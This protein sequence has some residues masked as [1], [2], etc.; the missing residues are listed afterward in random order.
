MR[1]HAMRG[2]ATR[3]RTLCRHVAALACALASAGAHAG[4]EL[5]AQAERFRW[6][7]GTSPRVTETGPRYGLGWSYES[8]ERGAWQLAYHGRLYGGSRLDYEGALLATNA[9]TRAQTDYRGVLNEVQAHY[10][11]GPDAYAGQLVGG[12]GWDYW[13]RKILPDQRE[14]YSVVYLRLGFSVDPPLARGWFGGGGFKLPVRIA[15]DAHLDTLGFDANPQLNPKGALSVYGEAGYR[16][17]ARWGL[18]AYYDS[19]RFGESRGVRVV[20]SGIPACT[21]GCDIVQPASRVDAVGLRLQYRL[22]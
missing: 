11:L 17:N 21:A 5:S 13:E 15:E 12:L 20:N 9:P 16:F 8:A 6:D 14:D 3:L 2:H 10:R 18:V 1:G 4:W 22:Q 7:E 19:Y